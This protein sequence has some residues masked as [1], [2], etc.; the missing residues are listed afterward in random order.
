MMAVIQ[1]SVVAQ[2]TLVGS[3][4]RARVAVVHRRRGAVRRAYVT[5]ASTMMHRSSERSLLVWERRGVFEYAMCEDRRLRVGQRAC[6]SSHNVLRAVAPR[7]RGRVAGRH[8]LV[9]PGVRRPARPDGASV[10]LTGKFTQARGPLSCPSNQV[11]S[12]PLTVPE[13]ALS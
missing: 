7:P 10:F 12:L 2:G 8:L 4:P 13:M 1:R 9:H 11:L 5:A 3:G 6:G